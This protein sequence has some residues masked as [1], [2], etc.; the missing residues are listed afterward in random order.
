MLLEIGYYVT[1]EQNSSN[2]HVQM[3]GE[4]RIILAL[5]LHEEN[6]MTYLWLLCVTTCYIF[7]ILLRWIPTFRRG[8]IFDH[9][10][11][12]KG[13]LAMPVKRDTGGRP[14]LPPLSR[15]VEEQ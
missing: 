6:C 12:F 5:V 1:G 3:S 8:S 15:D 14:A 13:A 11:T 2:S 7:D 4:L 10:L 9:D